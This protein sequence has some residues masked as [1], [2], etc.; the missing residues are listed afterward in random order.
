MKN[1][2]L[3]LGVICVVM[4]VLFLG[5]GRIYMRDL[6][7]FDTLWKLIWLILLPILLI[8]SFKLALKGRQNNEKKD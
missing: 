2:F 8:F 6:E 5:Y 1:L 7:W 4:V 3:F